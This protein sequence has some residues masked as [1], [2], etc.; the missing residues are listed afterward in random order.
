MR[1]L[2]SLSFI[3]FLVLASQVGVVA[4]PTH[5]KE[6]LL[7]M[8]TN[9]GPRFGALTFYDKFNTNVVV[10]GGK[11]ATSNYFDTFTFDPKGNTWLKMTNSLH[12][13]FMTDSAIEYH[14]SV[15]V[16]LCYGG[17]T[18]TG[19]GVSSQL[20]KYYNGVWELVIPTNPHPPA[21]I[22]AHMVYVPF[23]NL[24]Y[25]Y[26]GTSNGAGSGNSA[27]V[28]TYADGPS[29][30]TQVVCSGTAPRLYGGAMA[31]DAIH[32][33]LVIF[34]GLT[35][36]S[37][38]ASEN[39]YALRLP[40]H[41]WVQLSTTNS[42]PGLF[43]CAV[44]RV[45]DSRRMLVY[46]GGV[47]NTSLQD[48]TNGI[49]Q[50]DFSNYTWTACGDTNRPP[51]GMTFGTFTYASDYHMGVTYGGGTNF[52]SGI[53]SQLWYVADFQPQWLD[54]QKSNDEI[55][56]HCSGLPHCIYS[57][58]CSTNGYDWAKCDAF[59][60]GRIYILDPPSLPMTNPVAAYRYSP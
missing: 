59:I 27:E 28:W 4:E 30:W 24:M 21:L 34:G 20:W 31:Y 32:T 16:E 26:G 57:I 17:Q 44:G 40:S 2:T 19:L 35:A 56:A 52:T 38:F 49:W 23:E 1:I 60:S 9:P 37:G 33:Q 18:L 3:S 7:P 11:D 12:P 22:A 47:G 14:P 54:M 25:L 43:D 53:H 58:S 15:G 39:T 29:T 55:V 13:E 5:W 46:G 42:P 36:V 50:L 51:A 45:P 10:Y 8:A 6:P 41:E 48:R